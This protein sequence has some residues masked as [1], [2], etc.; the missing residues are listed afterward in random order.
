MLAHIGI[1]YKH[2]TRKLSCGWKG[3]CKEREKEKRE[4]SEAQIIKLN[5]IK[6]RTSKDAIEFILVGMGPTFKK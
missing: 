2:K 3:S 4:S 5:I 6:Q 1:P